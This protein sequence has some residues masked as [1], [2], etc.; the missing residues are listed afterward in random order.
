M[1]RFNREWRP[2]QKG[3]MGGLCGIALLLAG[4]ADNASSN[5]EETISIM[6]N[7]H[8][9]QVAT[10]S[11]I[12]EQIEEKAGV[13]LDITWAPDETYDDK[14]N[15]VIATQSFPRAMF[16]KNSESYTQMK[17]S[18]TDDVY[19][20]IGPYLDDYENLSKLDPVVLN[21]T[22]VDG[23]VFAL[24]RET[25]LSRWGIMY[26]KDWAANLGIEAP[27]TTED[28]YEMF[29]AFTEEDPDGNGKDDTFGVAVNSDLV[30]GGFKFVSSYFGT[31]NNWGE[32]DGE[33]MP[34]FMFE[35][36]IDTMNFFKKLRDDGYVNKDFP[37]TSKTS[38]TEMLTSGKAGAIVG[39]LCN[40]AGFQENLQLSHPEGELDVQNRISTA[41]GEPGTWATAGYG[42]VVLFPK[43]SNK[44]EEDLKEVLSLFDTMMEPDIYNS[45]VYGTEGEHYEMVD[46]KAKKLESGA[47][48]FETEIQPLLGLAIGGENAI[49]ALTRSFANDLD[50]KQYNQTMDNNNILIHD[51]TVALHS[52]T[53]GE[54]GTYLQ[55][56]IDDAT[57]Q[58]ML[59]DIDL[60]GFQSAVD[61]WKEEGGGQIIT[62]YNEAYQEAESN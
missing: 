49:D 34:E 2:I 60:E 37:V 61:K 40:A 6:A 46:G 10:D 20:E 41:D 8:T 54:N 59:G 27:E 4:C 25:P 19:W 9:P 1:N 7:V 39:C 23:K 17:D 53:Y 29:K 43:E 38:Q 14:M 15:T 35:E 48:S 5:G 16:V 32:K 3:L 18:L 58:Y 47:D 12:V 22:A 52:E 24:Y 21:N 50:E 62:E 26:R 57:I 42:S 13:N 44:T 36:Y 56:I 45:I 55:Q 11:P 28:L 31:P 51:P 33:L 30:Y